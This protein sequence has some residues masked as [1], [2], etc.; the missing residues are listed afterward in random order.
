MSHN[1]E[2]H[3]QNDEFVTLGIDGMS[4]EEKAV[5]MRREF[6]FANMCKTPNE[7][8][9]AD[10][11]AKKF[12]VDRRT[13][14]RDKEW[15]T[16]ER[17]HIWVRQLATHNFLFNTMEY[18]AHMKNDLEWLYSMRDAENDPMV[19]LAYQRQIS[20]VL[21]NIVAVGSQHPF[22]EGIKKLVEENEERENN[23]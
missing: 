20:E 3:E 14:Y 8:L 23:G 1:N 13:I 2:D 11:L 5:A 4:N 12:G 21:N 9:S 19:K 10:A 22:Y 16:R 7:R 17:P 6:V 18:E 15:C